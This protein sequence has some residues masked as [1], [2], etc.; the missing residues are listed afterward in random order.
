MW[1]RHVRAKPA[2]IMLCFDL[3]MTRFCLQVE[4]Q[5]LG[6]A[7]WQ[8]PSKKVPATS[9]AAPCMK[10]LL[11]NLQPT[12]EV[13][14]KEPPVLSCQ[15]H[16]HQ[17]S[18][19]EM[20]SHIK[21]ICTASSQTGASCTISLSLVGKQ[22]GGSTYKK[23]GFQASKP[24]ELH[25]QEFNSQGTAALRTWLSKAKA[26]P[27]QAAS[28]PSTM[29]NMFC[30]QGTV[31]LQTWLSRAKAAPSQATLTSVPS[32][33]EYCSTQA[34]ALQCQDISRYQAQQPP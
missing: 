13:Q 16:T 31:A 30:S 26:A 34:L 6:K 18:G 23:S 4:T 12:Q 25:G 14:T 15:P 11:P 29:P 24:A 20:I 32:S 22:K 28:P 19:G 27:P 21:A 5:N 10:T 33:Q 8:S 7:S 3:G 17:L 1:A 2:R 9:A